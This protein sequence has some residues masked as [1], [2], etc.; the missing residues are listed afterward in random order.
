MLSSI[1]SVKII[2]DPMDDNDKKNLEE[3]V[4]RRPNDDLRKLAGDNEVKLWE[5]AEALGITDT[6]LSKLLRHELTG[7]KRERVIRIIE[8][9]GSE[10]VESGETAG[11]TLTA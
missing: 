11:D 10:R 6:S 3:Q 4:M 9:L 8:R 7:R 1:C 2:I 5:I